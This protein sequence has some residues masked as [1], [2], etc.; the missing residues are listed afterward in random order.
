MTFKEFLSLDEGLFGQPS[1][2]GG[3]IGAIKQ[4]IKISGPVI[5][6]GTSVGRMM[7]AGKVNNPARP[8]R[9]GSYSKPMVTPSILGK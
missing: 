6:K 5:G 7:S 4:Q 8:A 1:M 9:L 2:A 3:N